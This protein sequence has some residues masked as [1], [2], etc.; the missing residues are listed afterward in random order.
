MDRSSAHPVPG[1]APGA[2]EGRRAWNV[3]LYR[4]A[5]TIVM[6][7]FFLACFHGIANY[8]QWGHNGY[9]GAAFTQAAR[10]SIRFGKVG[11]AQ[12]HTGLRAPRPA[13]MYTH[14]P[15]MLHLHLIG[16]YRLLG[17][18]EMV[19]RLVPAL[20][21]FFTLVLLF[22]MVRRLGGRVPALLSITIYTLTP[23]NLIFANMI[24]HEQGGIFWCLMFVYMYILWLGSYRWI[25]MLLSLIAVTMAVQFDW[26]GYYIS[27]FIAIHA[28]VMGIAQHR[29][30]FRWRPEY[31]WTVVF[32]AVVLLNFLL[33][34]LWVALYQGSLDQMKEAFQ[35]RA[36]EIPGYY[37]AIYYRTRD[38]QGVVPMTLVGSWILLLLGR[39]LFGKLRL[40]S[41]IPLFF[42]FAQVIHSV[43]FKQAGII[44]SYWTYYLSPAIAVGGAIVLFTIG[45]WTRKALKRI[46]LASGVR[47]RRS[48]ARAAIFAV[49][50]TAALGP[51]FIYQGQFAWKKLCWGFA[52]G[53]ASYHPSYDDQF[54]EVMWARELARFYDR[55]SVLYMMDWS[56]QW[57]IEFMYYL[58][59][60]FVPANFMG[61]KPGR[62]RPNCRKVILIDLKHLPSRTALSRLIGK[63]DIKVWAV[64]YTH[65][66][67]HET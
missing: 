67:A 4:V 64:S 17:F 1:E 53:A 51:L 47:F 45:G 39:L 25:Y 15:M 5:V 59:A 13:Q 22:V 9:N 50:V 7:A 33:F 56:V 18:H 26:P 27:F 62:Q 23:I 10:N 30:R 61:F 55:R 44:H 28:M 46:I 24:N 66:R 37:K 65:L 57:R 16:I 48:W 49:V 3:R 52:T 35:F 6:A 14:H 29:G 34:F 12:Y 21:S 20:Y 42:I 63:Y 54:G 8:W 2:G 38:L 19:G 43:V 36:E 40:L 11:Q 32:S 60:P 41:L 58:D 31:T